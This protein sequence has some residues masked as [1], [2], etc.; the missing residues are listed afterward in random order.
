MKR[1]PLV[2]GLLAVVVLAGIALP[3]QGQAVRL[4]YLYDNTVAN[5]ETKPDWGFACLV[6]GRGRTVLFDTGAKPL[7]LQHNLQALRIDVPRVQALVI[8]HDHGD[9]TLGAEGLAALPGLPVH[10]GEHFKLPPPFLAAIDRMGAKLVAG[11]IPRQVFPG[12]DLTAE[13]VRS[14]IYEQALLVDTPEGLVVVVGCAHP[15]IVAMLRHVADTKKRPIHAVVG[16]FHLLQTPADEVKAIIAEF[17][18][19][20]VGWAG[21]THCT[22][23]EAIRMFREAYGNRFIAGGAGTVV[24][25][26]RS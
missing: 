1:T 5:A 4:T 23:D 25:L 7:V 10:V 22:G 17:K 15:G 21:P 2:V 6:E 8:S 20:G 13:L 11:S 26:P 12:F 3:A 9:H 16:G 24:N 19:L 14:G 18:R